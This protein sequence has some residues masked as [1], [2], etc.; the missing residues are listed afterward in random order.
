MTAARGQAQPFTCMLTLSACLQVLQYVH[1]ALQDAVQEQRR[2]RQVARQA[3]LLDAAPPEAPE[4]HGAWLCCRSYLLNTRAWLARTV[5][6]QTD[7]CCRSPLRAAPKACRQRC[8]LILAAAGQ[9]EWLM[10]SFALS[11]LART[12]KKAPKGELQ[13]A[14]LE[15]IDSLLPLLTRLLQ[16]RHSPLV[17]QALRCL[18]PLLQLPLP[19]ALPACGLFMGP[20]SRCQQAPVGGDRLSSNGLGRRI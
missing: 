18:G 17:G 1:S 20:T 9:N 14:E 15:A 7:Q 16:S 2:E 19:G 11:L 6:Q 5:P 8:H 4:G 12:L 3:G 10:A 13:A